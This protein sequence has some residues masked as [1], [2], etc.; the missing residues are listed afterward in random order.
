MTDKEQRRHPSDLTAPKQ[1]LTGVRVIEMAGLGPVPYAGQLLSDMGAEVISVARPQQASNQV[2]DRGKRSV[3]MDLKNPQALDALLQLIDTGDI[4]IEGYRPGVAERLGF[5]PEL[6]LERVPHLVYA[7]MTGWGQ[8]G[9]WSQMAGHDIN[10][11]GLTGVL[12]AIGTQGEVPPPPLN[13]LGDYAGGSMFLVAGVLAALYAAQKSGRGD[14]IDVAMIDGAVSLFGLMLSMHAEGRWS[15][16]R[17]SNMLDGALP[18]YRCYRC[19]DN[20]FVAVGAL[21]SAFFDQMLVKLD[22]DSVD[23]GDRE[24][25]AQHSRQ[26]ALLE[27]CFANR[28][29]DDWAKLFDGSDACVTPVLDFIEASNHP[30]VKYRQTLIK[31]AGIIQSN[32]APRFSNFENVSAKTVSRGADT[33]AV[34]QELPLS[35]DLID[36]LIE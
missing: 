6:C 14:V 20:R 11:I 18:Y 2:E 23:Y 9:P 22:I 10:Y 25:P 27:S 30:H 7:R 36:S 34:L 4:L 26:H 16:D 12:H 8:N 35:A 5:G 29:R 24:D 31:H 15:T 21:E 32:I 17:C 1:P 3:V 33:E 28:E 13:L 19:Q